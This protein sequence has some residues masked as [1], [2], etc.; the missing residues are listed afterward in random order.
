MNAL[1]PSLSQSLYAQSGVLTA[2][3]PSLQKVCVVMA[4]I[5]CSKIAENGGQMSTKGR[6]AGQKI[7]VAV[8]GLSPQIV[9]ETL[10]ALA[11][12][13]D[14]P[15]IPD[16]IHLVT[17]GQG[18]MQ[19]RLNLLSERPGWFHRFCRDYDLHGIRFDEHQI[20]PIRDAAGNVL[21]DIRHPVDNDAAA[22]S[23]TELVRALT[24]DPGA[25]IHASIAGGRKTMGFYLGYAL[26]LY[27][28]SGDR[29]SHVLVSSPY[30]GHPEFFYPTPYESV[31]QGRKDGKTMTVDAR[32]AKITLADI[33][34]VR[35]RE[36][37]PSSLLDGKV[38]FSEVVHEAQ[39][40]LPPVLLDLYPDQCKI[41]AGGESITLRP[42]EF[43]LYWLMAQRVMDG[44][45]HMHW[46]D[47]DIGAELL[48]YYGRIVNTASGDYDRAKDAYRKGMDKVNFDPTKSRINQVIRQTLGAHRAKPYLIA[49]LGTI[50]GS[51]YKRQGLKVPT[52]AITITASL[53][54]EKDA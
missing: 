8:T 9:T 44:R 11:V 7:L 26:S 35:L 13:A 2:S 18:A 27:G 19:A 50:P 23:I 32:D 30:E 42:A 51:R 14:S 5:C 17:T 43:A 47:K 22:D 41:V 49:P 3:L 1:R 31:L 39:K 21:E 45:E 28:R 16:E 36:G 38:R 29:L 15:W 6:D 48:G 33:P 20:H 12:G 24:S 46:S 37:L 40:A 34:F 54:S 4:M 25:V 53:P 10:Y 52:T